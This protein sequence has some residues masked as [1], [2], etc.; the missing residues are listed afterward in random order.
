MDKMGHSKVREKNICIHLKKIIA[1]R[2]L[3]DFQSIYH[4][5]T[6]LTIG[7]FP[8]KKSSICNLFC[9]NSRWLASDSCQLK[10]IIK[11]RHQQIGAQG[12]R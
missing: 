2:L 3:Y 9:R 8:T 1:P 11:I 10:L 5:S 12:R 7:G 6:D 4:N